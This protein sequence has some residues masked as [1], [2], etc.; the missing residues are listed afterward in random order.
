MAYT[1]TVTAIKAAIESEIDSLVTL[2]SGTPLVKELE[3]AL[4][5][6]VASLKA[7]GTIAT[8]ERVEDA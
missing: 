3:A 4:E 1:N 7:A 8:S 6:A 5:R 2:N